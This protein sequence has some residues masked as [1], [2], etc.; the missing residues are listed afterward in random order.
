MKVEVEA[1]RGKRI[2]EIVFKQRWLS[3]KE[4]VYFYFNSKIPTEYDGFKETL[5]WDFFDCGNLNIETGV[6]QSD[7]GDYN[8][9]IREEWLKIKDKFVKVEETA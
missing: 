9:V 5:E 1:K 3:N 4:E 2:F 6:I 8:D 7:D